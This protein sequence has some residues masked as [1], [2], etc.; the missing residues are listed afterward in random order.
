MDFGTELTT[1]LG[2]N[3]TLAFLLLV[4]ANVVVGVLAALKDRRFELGEV[5]TIFYKVLPLFG[6]FLLLKIG[7]QAVGGASGD[8][9]A[10]GAWG[11]LLPFVK[12]TLKNIRE[13]G[14]PLEKLVGAQVADIVAKKDAPDGP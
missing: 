7:G 4:V 6:S 14:V 9:M 13:L 11:T 5:G 12:G 10:V 1:V 2:S 3:Q 8:M